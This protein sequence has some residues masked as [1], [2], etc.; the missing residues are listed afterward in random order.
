[1]AK[2]LKKNKKDAS[3]EEIFSLIDKKRSFV[4]EAGA[5]SGKTWTL[6]ESIKYVLKNK[7]EELKKNNQKI[8]CITYTNVAA[9]EIKNRIENNLLVNISTI[10]DFLWNLIKD[11]QYE[12]K[13]EIV[14]C[15]KESKTPIE[16]LEDIIFEKDIRY[17]GYGRNFE[18]G[19]ITHDDVILIASKIFD[20]Y[21]KIVNIVINKYPFIFIDEYQDTQPETVDILVE[22]VLAKGDKNI[23]IGFFGDSMQKIYNQ[24]VGKIENDLLQS[25][26]KLENFRCSK[27][28][29]ELLKKIRPELDQY[30]AG[31]NLDGDIYFFYCNNNLNKDDENY[32]KLRRTLEKNYGWDFNSPE[33]KILMLTHKGIANKLDYPNLLNIYN[34]MSSY[35][36]ERLYEHEEAFSE[37][38]IEKI[39]KAVSL[40]E[41]ERYGEFIDLLGIEG[42]KITN[43][44]DKIGIRK[45]MDRLI[46]LRENKKIKDVIDYV[47]KNNLI[48]KTLK[49]HNFEELLKRGEEEKKIAFYNDLMKIKYSEVINLNNYIRKFT[50]FS[51][52]HGIKGEEY[53]N[54]LVVIDDAAWNQY[55]FNEFLSGNKQNENRFNRSRNLFYVS[56]SR[57]KDQLAIISMSKIDK[58][59]ME[60]IDQWFGV[61]NV[62]D[63]KNIKDSGF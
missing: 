43:H 5:G 49:I 55:N 14:E 39:E 28:V 48:N 30:P 18:K 19:I 51:T 1:M 56:C 24:G 4:L 21:N 60:N 41:E 9:D 63:V 11:Y 38:F 15:N 8:I 12:L 36:R 13:E 31:N 42:F 29:I 61:K 16:G 53:N 17:F 35:G 34:K 47:F 25:V 26:T 6:I 62:F 27:R 57:A 45:S 54:V 20:K 52:K 37:L 2:R 33:T 44:K 59:A 40:Y 23:V 58:V 22:K 32:K 3:L 10:H 50:P 7:A 46:E